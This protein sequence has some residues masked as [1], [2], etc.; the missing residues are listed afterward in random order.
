RRRRD[1]QAAP[2]RR[3]RRLRHPQGKRRS[4]ARPVGGASPR[5]R[6][7]RRP[8]ADEGRA[9]RKAFDGEKDREFLGEQ[10]N[11]RWNTARMGTAMNDSRPRFG[12][13]ERTNAETLISLALAEDLNDEGDLTTTAVIP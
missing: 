9:A 6:R 4:G 8:S 3:Q 11:R 1:R 13:P 10:I 5:S 7:G 12:D 2:S